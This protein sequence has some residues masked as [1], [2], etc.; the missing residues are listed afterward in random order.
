MWSDEPSWQSVGPGL[1][2]TCRRTARCVNTSTRT[3][4]CGL[5]GPALTAPAWPRSPLVVCV[6]ASRN[7]PGPSPPPQGHIVLSEPLLTSVLDY[8]HLHHLP[9]CLQNISMPNRCQISPPAA[10]ADAADP[11]QQT[12]PVPAV[13]DGTAP[14]KTHKQWLTNKT[15]WQVMKQWVKAKVVPHQEAHPQAKLSGS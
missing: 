5:S 12:H 3:H 2:V 4:R 6:W 14:N 7:P 15:I 10:A 11:R 13:A 8:S 1:W 9:P